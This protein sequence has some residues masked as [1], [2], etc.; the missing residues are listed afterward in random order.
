[1][2]SN[3]F[4]DVS[5]FPKRVEIVVEKLASSPRAAANSFNVSNAS[6]ALSTKFATAVLTNAVVAICLLLVSLL[7]VGAV[8]VPLK[9]VPVLEI[10]V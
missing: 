8:G 10:V 5:T 7:A 9:S 1:M 3:A 2:L 6:G 4:T